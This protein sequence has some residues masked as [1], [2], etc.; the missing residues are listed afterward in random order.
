MPSR[1]LVGI[2]D[3]MFYALGS[4]DGSSREAMRQ[5]MWNLTLIAFAALSLALVGSL[6]LARLL[7]K[8]IGHLS[9]SLNE[10]AALT[11]SRRPCR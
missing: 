2:A 4:I 1:R 5:A 10:M 8:P 11:P 3:T 6:L 7:A 9:S